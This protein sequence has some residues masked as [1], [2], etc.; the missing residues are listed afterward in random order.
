MKRVIL[1]VIVL[2]AM[3]SI[4]EAA[5]FQTLGMLRT[6]D[7]YVL[8]HKAAEILLV[9]YYRDVAR[10]TYVNPDQNGFVPYGMLGVGI[11][12]RVELG[13]F[14]GDEVYYMNLKFKLIQETTKIPQV[15]VGIDNLFSPVNRHRAQDW[16]PTT[17]LDWNYSDHP[18]KTDYEYYSP[19]IVGSKQ[20]VIG[21]LSWMFNLGFGTNRFTG[22]VPRSRIFNGTFASVELSPFRDFAIQGEF[23]GHDFNAGIKYSYKNFGIKIGAQSL[24]DLTKNNGYEENLRVAFGLSYLFDKYATSKRRPDLRQ[25][26][27]DQ[28]IDDI[29]VA[30]VDEPLVGTPASGDIEVAV[31]DPEVTL[32]TPGTTI[33]TPG[34]VVQTG[35]YRELS[36][37]VKELLA[38]LK[39]LSD[40]RQKAQQALIDLR[41]W[42]EEL[43]KP[44]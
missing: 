30:V 23:S 15:S 40:E 1:S 33:Q 24:E 41:K 42:L 19:Y 37:E 17:A 35:A 38:E 3:L 10:P 34:A 9:G 22:Q 31:I 5:P 21:G 27:M 16:T 14:G 43:K 12:D 28:D 11:L 36:P 26:A 13:F 25:F 6:P 44:K 7:A 32:V 4:A 2:A 20:A 8:P 39:K 18:D 29:E